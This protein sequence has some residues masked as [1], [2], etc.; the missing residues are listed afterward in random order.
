MKDKNETTINLGDKVTD[1]H[2][3]EGVMVNISGVPAI[4]FT[5]RGKEQYSFAEKMVE[6]E[7]LITE[8][9]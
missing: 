5:Y 8:V 6:S 2:S 3:N 9:A 7:L 1:T 4:K